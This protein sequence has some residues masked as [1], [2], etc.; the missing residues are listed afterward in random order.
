MSSRIAEIRVPSKCRQLIRDGALVSISTSGGKDSQ[1]M[2]ILLSRIVPRDRLVA[3]HAPL[4]EVEWPN[5]VEFIRATL[6][7][8]IPLI[9]APVASCKTGTTTATGL[10][11]TGTTATIV[12]EDTRGVAISAPTLT[13][14]EGSTATYTVVLTSQPTATVTVTPSRSSGSGDVTFSPASLSFGTG[15]W[16]TAK[17]VTVSAAE[18]DDAEADE[19]VLSHAVSGGDYGANS[20]TASSVDVTVGDNETA[21]TTVA[22][23]VNP[24]S[25][26][27][28]AGATTVTVTGT[29]DGAPRTADTVVT[30][31][32]GA[33][34]DDA[35]EGTDYGTVADLTLTVDAGETTGTAT[36]TL[37]PTDDDVDEGDETLSVEGRHKTIDVDVDHDNL[38]ELSVTATTAT[39]VDDDTR[40]VAVSPIVLT[41][42]EG[43]T[44]TYTVVLTSQPTATVTVTPSRSS[45]SGDVT[46]SPSSLS[47]GTGDWNTAKTVTVSAAEDDDAEADEAVL[48]H[49]VSGGDYG[50]NS[51]TAS[52]VDVTVGDNETASTTV[53]LSVNPVS[54][55][56]DAGATSVTVTGTLDGA[57]RT[58]DTVVTVTVGAS[59]DGAAEGTDY[60]SVADLTL[61]VDAGETTGTATFTLTPTDDDVD[62]GD[63]TLSVTGT[64][65][66]TGLTVTETTATIVDDD[67]TAS[68]V[69]GPVTGLSAE[70]VA[71]GV[72][73]SW[74][75]PAGPIRG[76][77]IEVSFN[78]GDSWAAIGDDTP[79]GAIGYFHLLDM[80][81][82]ETR[83]YRVS[84]IANDGTTSA[85][86]PVEATATTEAAGLTATGIA[87]QDAPD[88]MPA[89]D[90]CWTPENPS[91]T[92]LRD[93]ALRFKPTSQPGGLGSNW[94]QLSESSDGCNGGRG[95]GTRVTAIVPNAEFGLQFRARY[96]NQWIVSD[97]AR[98]ISLDSTL[99]LR[100]EVAAGISDLSGDTLVPDTVCPAYDDPA[101]PADEA[102]S[103]FVNIGFTTVD[104]VHI[105]YEKVNGFAVADDVAVAKGTAELVADSF[106]TQLGYR[107][108]ITPT[109]WGEDVVVSVPAGAV[110]HPETSMPNLA[111]N[112]FRRKTSNG[113]GCAP[114]AAAP[115]VAFVKIYG[116]APSDGSWPA[117][118]VIRV[119]LRFTEPM[120]VSTA[121]GIPTLTL[122]L[123][124][125]DDAAE[126]QATYTRLDTQ[127]DAYFEYAVTPG[128]GLVRQVKLVENSLTLNGRRIAAAFGEIEAELDHPGASKH[129]LPRALTARWQKLPKV[130]PGKDKKF[131]VRLKFNRYTTIGPRDLREHAVSVTGGAIDNAWRV[132]D[133]NGNPSSKLFAVR[134]EADSDDRP[135]TLS[136]TADGECSEQGAICTADG[137]RLSNA[138]SV[139]ISNA[140]A[141]IS[142][143]DAEAHEA[144]GAELVFDVT[145]DRAVDYKVK[146]NYQT[147]DGTAVAGEDYT[148][149]SGTLVFERGETLQTVSVPVLEDAH[150][151]DGEMLTLVLS[152]PFHGRIADG[153]A[154]GTIR[155]TDPMP[156]AWLARF[157]RT[158]AD[159]ILDAVDRRMTA[160]PVPGMELSVAGR[161]IGAGAV[162]NGLVALDAEARFGALRNWLR[163]EA[164][165]Q[166]RSGETRALTGRDLLTGSSF[167][168][169][170]GSPESSIGTLWGRGAV[171]RFDGRQG[172]VTLD[173]EVESA[174]LGADFTRGRGTAGLV[175]SRS[176][177]EGE[178]RS[179]ESGGEIEATLTGIFPWGRYAVDE[180]LSLW[181][182]LGYGE[183]RLTLTPGV[184][185]P[186][187]TDMDLAMAAAGL[188]SVLMQAPAE[189]GLEL[190]TTSDMLLVTT[191][192]EAVGSNLGASD[193]QVTRLRVG[194]EGMW[195][196]LGTAD[197]G[198]F[199]PAL[200][201][202]LRH[203]GG[204]A[205]TGLGADIGAGLAWADPSRGLSA[206]LNARGLLTHE[207]SGFR[208][209]GFAGSIV[210][211]PEPRSDRGPSLT[212]S[213]TVGAAAKGG[214]EAL[215]R[216][217]TARTLDA[218]N[219][220]E[221][222]DQRSRR[223]EAKLDYGWPVFA[224]RF[225]AAPEI[226]FRLS[227]SD[228]EYVHGWRLAEAKR[229]G[230]AFGLDV[231]AARREPMTD[232]A[233]PEHRLGFGLGWRRDDSTFEFRLEGSRLQPVNDNRAPE[234][235][236]GLSLSARW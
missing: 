219:D 2:T 5:T 232:D 24:A 51:V 150:E 99:D 53:A 97:V 33:S 216:P 8:G 25:V 49:A 103:F 37:T 217:E 50:A 179:G 185:S 106:H 161:R 30:V 20:V 229:S 191:G 233:A 142:A 116:G 36:F 134:V 92:F 157:G 158:V 213:Q 93:F 201:I 14:P 35:A 55:D 140:G 57:P 70:G 144:P 16:S 46:F 15:D 139:T 13:V 114:E 190:S 38:E 54:V 12:D 18:D 197:G 58:A 218:A 226:G 180:R 231:E 71:T 7:P 34:G 77:L 138:P 66:A 102:G 60:T 168:L 86:A 10:T 17:T 129:Q 189:G 153:E 9:L 91:V 198:S 65:T 107:V 146:V 208:E 176:R 186:M 111:S 61:T 47:F 193:A 81:A 32:V 123:G 63:E 210:W 28:D 127:N 122:R 169:T 87:V 31:T 22:L 104:P 23:S 94:V 230:L 110:T 215:L 212:L 6:P 96:G 178:Y 164:E 113:E 131:V 172:K 41:V 209:R 112:E 72:S 78:E 19:A 206:E 80:E 109:S 11:V 42:P 105:N 26:D 236:I 39:I 125:G 101:T 203:D 227:E 202:G 29:L 130:H 192:S 181:G 90:V 67:G 52:S 135:V 64:T 4:A 200:E 95:V 118:D 222:S 221:D 137:A 136:L 214:V 183:G 74:T 128:Q 165:E 175:L 40:G 108:K 160:S 1:A 228:R 100:T 162:G 21:S 194:L 207:A 98:A 126:V 83:L 170:E 171:S 117:G 121:G 204:D 234:H 59:G 174:M 124:D 199:L 84:T 149:V 196:G 27:E 224:G 148:A 156:Q 205:E 177:G 132:K 45:G 62:E 211:D 154:V 145:L 89:I 133:S 225:T 188:R 79:P 115:I 147:V 82:G 143:A 141:M 151:D 195:R 73:L 3:V 235:R 85:S 167:A 68:T 173:G 43:S 220:N 182:V 69:P 187:G 120:A 119:S 44:A 76:Y 56:E 166:R 223:L 75:A 184:G 163:G 48:S 88:G 159:Q 155:N 152:D